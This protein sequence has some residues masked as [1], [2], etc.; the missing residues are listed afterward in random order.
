M[1]RTVYKQFTMFC[2][3]FCFTQLRVLHCHPRACE[4]PQGN[5]VNR[6]VR[7]LFNWQGPAQPAR[8]AHTETHGAVRIRSSLVAAAGGH[9]APH[10]LDIAICHAST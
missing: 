10:G 3:R 1:N 6:C 8:T 4:K 9:D 5:L 2:W 7:E